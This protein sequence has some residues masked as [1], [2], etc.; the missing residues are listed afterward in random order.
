MLE[1][2]IKGDN[3]FGLTLTVHAGRTYP[4]ETLSECRKILVAYPVR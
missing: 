4:I 1:T 2:S 3:G